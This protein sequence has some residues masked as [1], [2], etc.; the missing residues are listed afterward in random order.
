MKTGSTSIRNISLPLPKKGQGHNYANA[1]PPSRRQ[2]NAYLSNKNARGM[3]MT[4]TA[5]RRKA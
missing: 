5:G 2:G 4:N 3:I 1:L